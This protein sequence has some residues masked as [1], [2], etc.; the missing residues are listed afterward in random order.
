MRNLRI[1]MFSLESFVLV[2]GVASVVVS[3]VAVLIPSDVVVTPACLF[4][5]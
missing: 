2:I 1:L 5:K 3:S 4:L